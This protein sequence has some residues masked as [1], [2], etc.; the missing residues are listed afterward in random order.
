[1]P[2]KSRSEQRL[3]GMVH[4][5]QKG[6][7]K[8]PSPKIKEVAEHISN[9]DAKHFAQTK[10]EGL[11][12]KVAARGDFLPKA[13]PWLNKTS[14]EAPVRRLLSPL[15]RGTP[16]ARI[17]AGDAK[18]NK[19]VVNKVYPNSTNIIPKLAAEI[20]PD[21]SSII[22]KIF[23][24]R[25]EI[26]RGLHPDVLRNLAPKAKGLQEYEQYL[27]EINT[28][29][30]MPPQIPQAKLARYRNLYT[31]GFM[32]EAIANDVPIEKLGQVMTDAGFVKEAF[33]PLL[34]E[35]AGSVG[36]GMLGYEGVDALA[37]MAASNAGRYAALRAAGQA[38]KIPLLARNQT[39]TN[40]AA[41][42]FKN[43]RFGTAGGIAAPML[44]QPLTDAAANAVTP[45][46]QQPPQFNPEEMQSSYPQ[47][48]Y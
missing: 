30:A 48:Q 37:G 39:L 19:N 47:G 41:K 35:L 3:F 32:K 22:E 25:N 31:I 27:N 4:A 9:T 40:F 7:L 13:L 26:G 8:N 42:H 43:G 15:G 23:H 46:P 21:F 36:S 12:E 20:S 10:H 6:E 11:P 18:F 28:Q 1:M 33:L 2:S 14:P 17:L 16:G 38:D 29:H 34:I 24:G 44:T 45:K 5:Y